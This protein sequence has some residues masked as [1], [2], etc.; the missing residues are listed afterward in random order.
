M[1]YIARFPLNMRKTEI[2]IKCLKHNRSEILNDRHT[3]DVPYMLNAPSNLSMLRL[4][5]Q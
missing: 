4:T 1:P 5:C 2:K 3:F